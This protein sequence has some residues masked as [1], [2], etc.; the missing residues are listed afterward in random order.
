MFIDGCRTMQN[1]PKKDVTQQPFS[2]ASGAVRYSTD[3]VDVFCQ[4]DKICVQAYPCQWCS[5]HLFAWSTNRSKMGIT[6]KPFM[7]CCIYT[8]QS[9]SEPIF[10]GGYPNSSH[11]LQSMIDGT[12]ITVKAQLI[13]IV[14]ISMSA[15]YTQLARKRSYHGTRK[16]IS[17]D[18][19]RMRC[20]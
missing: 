15:Y 16:S 1:S 12:E 5:R 13:A 2:I 19:F 20:L 10:T 11:M 3:A 4:D 8:R 17:A 18:M 14:A 9:G 6:P 7:K